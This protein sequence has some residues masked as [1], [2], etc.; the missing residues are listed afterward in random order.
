MRKPLEL[1]Q[2]IMSLIGLIMTAGVLIVNQSNKIATAELR[3][4][5]LEQ[6]KRDTKEQFDKV[7]IR[8]DQIDSQLTT[9]RV[10]LEDKANRK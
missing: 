5:D 8:L 3:I 7:N 10:L 4:S 1:W 2:F 6:N 9:I